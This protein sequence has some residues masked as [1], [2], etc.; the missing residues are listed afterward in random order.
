MPSIFG[1]V[2]ALENAYRELRFGVQSKENCF[3][4]REIAAKTIRAIKED[5][6]RIYTTGPKVHGRFEASQL[7]LLSKW[8][9]EAEAVFDNCERMAAKAA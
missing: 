1:K 3:A 8:Q 4:V 7:D 6:D 5:R 2:V 9:G